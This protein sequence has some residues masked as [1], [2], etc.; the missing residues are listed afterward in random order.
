MADQIVQS[1][2]D[3]ISVVP[4]V[5]VYLIFFGI[6]YIENLIPPMPGD[7]I[8]AFG[9]YLAAEGL[10][11]LFPVWSLTVVASVAG[12]MT[13]Y[14]LGHRWGA[15]IEENRDSHF[16]LRFIDYKYFARGKKWMSRWGQGV[17]VANRFLAG[18]RSVISLTAGMS[19]LKITPTIL[20]SLVSS[21]LW[22]TLLLAMGWVI[23]DNWQVIGEYLIEL[24]KGH[25]SVD[26]AVYRS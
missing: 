8:V 9:G 24:W 23:R 18:T 13:M 12:F 7:V 3:W 5:G 21:V 22:N 19:H 25:F 4:P 14:W 20:S 26:S 17:V 10:I 11:G 15:Q 1:I 6:A 2:V 16:L